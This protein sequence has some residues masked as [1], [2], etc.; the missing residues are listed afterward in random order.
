MNISRKSWHY[1]MH[2]A[3]FTIFNLDRFGPRAYLRGARFEHQPK[4]LCGYFWST[5]TLTALLP[6]FVL[7]SILIVLPIAAVIIGLEKAHDSY[8]RARPRPEGK[9]YKTDVFFE[10]VGARK[11]KVCPLLTVVD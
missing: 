10:Y 5:L 9:P 7:I 2:V 8:R 4:T 3:L 6:L 11:K 1:R